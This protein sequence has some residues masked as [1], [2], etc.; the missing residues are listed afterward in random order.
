MVRRAQLARISCVG[1]DG[2]AVTV[3]H[4]LHAMH[5][6]IWIANDLLLPRVLLQRLV[7][8][9]ILVCKL[10]YDIID[11]I[12]IVIFHFLHRFLA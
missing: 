7:V 2:I 1:Q 3:C 8:H 12:V 5:Y 6:Q 4:L 10:V 9:A 11:V